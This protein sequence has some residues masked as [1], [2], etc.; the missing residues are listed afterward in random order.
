M[1]QN[2][3]SM[4][5]LMQVQFHGKDLFAAG[6][7]SSNYSIY[8]CQVRFENGTYK[9][10]K[11][12][13]LAVGGNFFD[14]A[15]VF[16]FEND[17]VY[18]LPTRSV[19]NGQ[20]RGHTIVSY[21][22]ETELTG[23]WQ[24]CPGRKYGAE[25]YK[26]TGYVLSGAIAVYQGILYLGLYSYSNYSASV[27]AQTGQMYANSADGWFEVAVDD[28]FTMYPDSFKVSGHKSAEDSYQED[29]RD[30]AHILSG[31]DGCCEIFW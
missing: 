25:F 20:Q 24:E 31:A 10:I 22:I 17:H 29:W 12:P 23:S 14:Q 2:L 21:P 16:V 28:L 26:S 13:G 3:G 11:A 8:C 1:N 9:V 6:I 30:S 15:P 5:S 27:P 7:Y 19:Y 4:F 18:L